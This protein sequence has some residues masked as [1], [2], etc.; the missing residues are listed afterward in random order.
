[1]LLAFKA[2]KRARKVAKPG[3]GPYGKGSRKDRRRDPPRRNNRTPRKLPPRPIAP[4]P[5]AVL[6]PP[7][8]EAAGV[9]LLGRARSPLLVAIG[10][11]LL[12]LAAWLVA[13]SSRT[14]EPPQPNVPPFD[15][16]ADGGGETVTFPPGTEVLVT[17]TFRTIRT[18]S[19]G[20]QGDEFDT[21]TSET[22]PRFPRSMDWD[23]P[24]TT[25][26]DDGNGTT[27]GA[28]GRSL[29]LRRADGSII[30][31][32][33]FSSAFQITTGPGGTIEERQSQTATL[34]QVGGEPVPLPGQQLPPAAELR[35]F[36]ITPTRVAP[37]TAPS[38]PGPSPAPIPT[39]VPEVEPQPEPAQVPTTVPG[40]LPRAVPTPAPRPSAP[41]VSPV[42]VPQ[43]VPAPVQG[44]PPTLGSV[45]T[46]TPTQVVK[47]AG[48]NVG[49]PG[50]TPPPTLPGI[51]TEL[52]RIE[53]KA[54]A[55]LR[56]VGTPSGRG[57]LEQILIQELET[58]I[59]N[60]LLDLFNDQPAGQYELFPP[61]P[62]P[63]NGEPVQPDVA[64]WSEST[65]PLV[66]IQKRIDA[67]ALLLQYHKDQGQ[68]SCRTAITGRPVTVDFISDPE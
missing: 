52:G 19:G 8:V 49:G 6:A 64:A 39:R 25:S 35:P 20:A 58:A 43:A 12:L 59:R 15:P 31:K 16:L 27:T 7:A 46:P 36:P 55:I 57:L 63:T 65:N 54:E 29:N 48:T 44:P 67:V 45:L 2:P 56:Q 66:D 13:N 60:A 22:N 61:C 34:T 5:S 26:F 32:V 38:T 1:V 42:P 53:Q 68:P 3:L 47:I 28:T 30:R 50:A 37:A 40:T 14:S 9:R 17:E 10:L 23:V 62:G 4:R 41:Q 18:V 21:S 51:A 11:A 33:P 24:A